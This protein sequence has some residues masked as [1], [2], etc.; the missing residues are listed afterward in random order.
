MATRRLRPLA[1]SLLS[2][3]A[4]LAAGLALAPELVAAPLRDPLR[5]HGLELADGRTAPPPLGPVWGSSSGGLDPRVAHRGLVRLR[6]EVGPIWVAWSDARGSASG[7]VLSGVDAPGTVASAARAEAFARAFLGRHLG[8][9]APGSTEGDFEVVADE[10]AAGVRT[11]GLRQRHGGVPVLGGQISLRFSADRLVLVTSQALPHVHVPTRASTVTPQ[12]AR[13]EARA[14]VARDHDPE[15]TGA[16]LELTGPDEGTHVLPVWTGTGWDYHEVVRVTVGSRAPIAR[17]VVYLDAETGAPIAREQLVRSAATVRFDV[18]VRH[19]NAARQDALAPDL[20]VL[21]GG[22][23]ATTDGNGLVALGQSPTTIVTSVEGPLVQVIDDVGNP[24]ST[25]F[26]GV[27]D[28]GTVVWSAPLDEQVDAQ[29]SAF[30]HASIAKEHVRAIDPG[31]GWLDQTLE[32]NVNLPSGCNA[33]SDGDSVYFLLGDAA[34]QNTAR[35]ADVVYHEIGHSVHAQSIIPGVGGFDSHLSEGISDYFAATIVDDSGMGRGFT[36]TDEPLR[37]IDPDGFEYMW[38]QDVS[39]DPHQ[40]GRIISG[41]LWDLRVALRDDLGIDQGTIQADTIWYQSIRRAVDIPSMYPEALATDDDDGDLANGTP[42]ACAINA[43]F[44]AHGLLDPSQLGDVTVDVAAVAG[45]QEVSVAQTVPMFPGCAVD[46]GTAELRWRLRGLPDDVNTVPMVI[47]GGAWVATI[48]AQD[49]G[50][51]V[52]Y[53]VVLSYPTGASAVL[54]RNPA[55]PWYQLFFGATVPI[56]CLDDAANLGEWFF[57]GNG[58]TWSFGPLAGGGG[59]DPDAPWDDDGVLLSQD[60]LY[61]PFANTAATGP[62]IDITG[63]TDVRLHYRRWLSVEDGFFD[64][65]TLRVNDEDV[66]TNLATPQANVHHTDGEWRFH[67]LPLNDFLGDGQVQLQFALDSDG[68]LELGGWTVDGLCVVEVVESACGDGMLGGDEECDDGNL[69]PG[70]GCDET[71]ATEEPTGT[72]GEDTSGSESSDGDTGGQGTGALDDTTAGQPPVGGETSEGSASEGSTEPAQDG[73]GGSDGCG[74][75]SSEPHS[76]WTSAGLV[77]LVAARL[78][79]RRSVA[80][81]G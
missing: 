52:E 54:P 42:N 40:T 45:G 2:A 47:D 67:D 49:T 75:T 60:G 24:A 79:R 23:P 56:Y 5:V 13:A 72:T 6:D 61:P 63:H 38:P 73:E 21:Q 53:Q 57:S 69:E 46:L 70:D 4:F 31:L 36:Y 64:Q 25:S 7:L 62:F 68:G 55:D 27:V 50:V 44:A 19:P 66:W 34:C 58:D 8:V 14:F 59:L 65:A 39:P 1:S 41:T 17:W 28:G 26:P 37:E 74:C 3:A 11:V 48:P 32:V 30:V 35:L 18:P 80:R 20:Y 33:L 78:R 12:H 15:G 76:A 29:L 81:H 10:L 51:V 77:L 22:M 16:G 43:A 9:L 71:C